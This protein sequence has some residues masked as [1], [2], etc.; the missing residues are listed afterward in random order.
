MN[1]QCDIIRGVLGMRRGL[2]T[3]AGC[4]S[5]APQSQKN[6]TAKERY[7]HYENYNLIQCHMRLLDDCTP[8]QK[9][10]ERD[11][12]KHSLASKE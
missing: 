4:V 8:A 6:Q 3:I 1:W 2:L 10:P 9:R 7:C 12:A 5:P 11:I